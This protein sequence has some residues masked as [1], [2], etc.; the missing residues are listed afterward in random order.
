MNKKNSFL[1]SGV[2]FWRT[3]RAEYGIWEHIR[4]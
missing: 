2:V 1:L 3:G 4:R